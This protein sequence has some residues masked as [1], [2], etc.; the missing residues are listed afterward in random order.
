MSIDKMMSEYKSV[1]ELQ[2]YADAQFK[3]IQELSKKNK[4]LEEE[5]IELKKTVDSVSNI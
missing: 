4:R 1:V 2:A 5:N 3:T